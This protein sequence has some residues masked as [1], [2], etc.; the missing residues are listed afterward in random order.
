MKK[1]R[2]NQRQEGGG[3]KQTKREGIGEE[4]ILRPEKKAQKKKKKSKNPNSKKTGIVKIKRS[5]NLLPQGKKK[6][7]AKKKEFKKRQG[8]K[9]AGFTGGRLQ[10]GW[11]GW[12]KG[13]GRGEG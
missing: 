10:Q 5:E 12:K 6:N 2:G 1:Y 13:I 9:G 4:M 11:G 7:K 3:E 8:K